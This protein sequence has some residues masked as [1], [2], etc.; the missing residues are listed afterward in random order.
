MIARAFNL[1]CGEK[2]I[3]GP[4]R[5]VPRFV[6]LADDRPK[7][8]RLRLP[9]PVAVFQEIINPDIHHPLVNPRLV[10]VVLRER[11]Q[12]TVGRIEIAAGGLRI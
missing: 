12:Q 8:I 10:G 7:I 6:V 4:I 9:V 3:I 2:Q 1:F 5:L 11:P